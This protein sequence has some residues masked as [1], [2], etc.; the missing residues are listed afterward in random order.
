MKNFKN[1]SDAEVRRDFPGGWKGDKENKFVASG[2]TAKENEA[3]NFTKKLAQYRKTCSALHQGKHTQF[4]PQ[5]G[6][7][8]YFRHNEQKTVMVVMSQNEQAKTISTARY[9]EIMRGFTKGK[10][11]LDDTMLNN[12]N[13]LQVPPMSVQVIELN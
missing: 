6:I 2:R 9:A 3:F 12:L 7:Y 13:Q 1:P 11:V 8:V 10:N 5:D 4:I